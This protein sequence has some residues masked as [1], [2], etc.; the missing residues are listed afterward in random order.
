MHHTEADHENTVASAILVIFMLNGDSCNVFKKR[1]FYV[2]FFQEQITRIKK[3]T[4][5]AEKLNDFLIF[6]KISK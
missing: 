2:T 4:K 5:K 3:N 6:L 1:F